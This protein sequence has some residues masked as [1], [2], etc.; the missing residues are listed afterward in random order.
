MLLLFIITRVLDELAR[1][2]ELWDR[3]GDCTLKI[4]C[5]F[6]RDFR[7]IIVTLLVLID[8]P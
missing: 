6:D 4:T 8:S 3:L 7:L 5:I 1:L 2:L